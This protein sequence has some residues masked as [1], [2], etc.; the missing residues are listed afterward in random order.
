MEIVFFSKN[1]LAS[2]F[3]KK[4]IKKIGHNCT[5]AYTL[6]EMIR[7][8]RQKNPEIVFAD[9]RLINL[10]G[11]DVDAHLKVMSAQ[12]VYYDFYKDYFSGKLIPKTDVFL[13]IIEKYTLFVEIQNYKIQNKSNQSF[14]LPQKK[15]QHHH[16]ILLQHFFQNPNIKISSK[17]LLNLFWAKK[18][19]NETSTIESENHLSTLYSYV[20][21]VKK[22]LVENEIE[23]D[24]FRS[25][26]G[27]YTCYVAE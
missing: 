11:F 12:F 23:I 5:C 10:Y 14:V 8:I 1:K 26:K 4:C 3:L 21:Q 27:F 9:T 13:S 7:F 24:I 6:S 17:N 22:F 16:I 20:S 18:S 2:L 19:Q 15:L 25:G